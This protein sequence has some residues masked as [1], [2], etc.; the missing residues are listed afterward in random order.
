MIKNYIKIA[1]RNIF[2]NKAYSAINII[3]L[4]L[5]ITCCSLLFMFVIDE[6]TFDSFHTKRDQIYRIVERHNDENETNYYAFT[7]APVGPALVQDYQEVEAMTRLFQF[8]GHLNFNQEDQKFQE[9][10]YYVIDNSFFEIFDFELLYGDPVTA[11][12]KPNSIILDQDW[13]N[14]LYG[15]SENAIGKMLSMENNSYLAKVTGVMKNIPQNSHLQAKVL[16]SIPSLEDSDFVKS[17]LTGWERYGASTY[18]LLNEQA[19][20][21]QLESKMPAFIQKYFGEED[22]RVIQLQSLSDIHFESEDIQ[23]GA[24]EQHGQIAYIYIFMAIGIFMIVIACI[25]YMNLATAKSM[26]RGKEI[27][28]RKV[29][30]A[31]RS[32]LVTQFLSESILTALISF[33][34][35]IGL[36]DL[37]LPYF[38]EITDKSFMF[39]TETFSGVFG[40]LFV[41]TMLVGL[42][43][44]SYPAFLLS[45]LQ[46]AGILKGEMSSGKGSL[47]L[48]K[49][50]VITQF[51]LSIIMIISTVVASKQMNFIK[52]QSLGFDNSQMIVIDI[53]NGNVRNR[54]ETMKTEFA[55]SPYVKNVAVSSRV[56]GEW[57]S[58]REVYM[59][60]AEVASIDS[61]R[62]YYIGFDKDML[63]TYNMKLVE[64]AN[65]T[66][67]ISSDSM[68]VMINEKAKEALSLANPIGAT[69][70]MSG[71]RG[72][73]QYRVVGVVEN[74]NFQS[75]HNEIAPMVVGY[76]SNIFQSIDYFTLK[77][78][79][80]HTQDVLAH[81]TKVHNMFDENTPI[82]YHFLDDQWAEF[83]KNDQRAGDIFMIGATITI[84]IAC[85]GL[86]GL[87]SFIV[88]KRTKEIGVRKVLGASISQL[89]V[90]LSKTFVI[91]VGIA[92]LIAIP[93]SWYFMSEW[94]STFAFKF[95]LGVSEFALAGISALLIALLSVS[96]RV[97]N[98]ATLNPAH[99]L[100]D[101]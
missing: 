61:I 68:T 25:N 23:F 24:D 41:I 65:F 5:G 28:M 81:A 49:V 77:I 50:L 66:G 30:G 16:I 88:Q 82:E 34:L 100:K 90:L 13:A 47:L 98:A 78:D 17:I 45:R 86:F 33:A 29:S 101:E 70:E 51:S 62:T 56:P 22:E 20:A 1:I 15:S 3:G 92:F 54:F 11:L 72:G 57:K 83:Y 69:I 67:N 99:T 60:N 79:G 8:G 42:L 95:D 21:S 26:H 37:L 12:A 27:G 76:R 96:Y 74:F 87:A 85:M 80:T 75:L 14:I 53:N 58:I 10:Q 38:N 93:I 40:L 9:R 2:R 36:V 6:M 4:T 52:N 59:R 39:N 48:R 71:R 44:G 94:L 46:P 97:I 18:L 63:D 89:F 64:G 7:P 19:N 73:G 35:S 31:S 32:Q 55:K 84:L 43:S 91:Q